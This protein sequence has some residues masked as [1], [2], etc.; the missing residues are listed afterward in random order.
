MTATNIESK[1]HDYPDE[2][3]APAAPEAAAQAEDAATSYP[4]LEQTPTPV[5]LRK[6][7]V[8]DLCRLGYEKARIK[9]EANTVTTR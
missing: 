7:P 2:Q 6:L 8:A 4:L 9:L 3:P 5:E 1:A